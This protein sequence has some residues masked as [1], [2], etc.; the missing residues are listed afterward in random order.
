MNK[1]FKSEEKQK[2]TSNYAT[3]V[4]LQQRQ[5]LIDWRAPGNQLK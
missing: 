1:L 3:N 4:L 5:S 2:Q